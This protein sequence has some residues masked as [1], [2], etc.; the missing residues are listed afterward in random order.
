MEG[1]EF[2][3]T[4]VF[5]IS[6]IATNL[7]EIIRYRRENKWYWTTEEF[8]QLANDLVLALLSLHRSNICHNDIRP[9]NVLF[10]IA[11]NCYQLGNFGN[12]TKHEFKKARKFMSTSQV[13]SSA[14][15]SAP[16][17]KSSTDVDLR[18]ADIYSLGITLLSA[19]FLCEPIN[20]NCAPTLCQQF[21][22][23]PIMAVIQDMIAPAEKRA[24]I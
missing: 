17:F 22:R 20:Q 1:E 24:N 13:R 19:F 9:C 23:Y 8:N 7:S 6:P 3:N 21:N 5:L 18:E 16:E 11:S 10:S 14:N 4:Q 15:Y 2:P 12:A